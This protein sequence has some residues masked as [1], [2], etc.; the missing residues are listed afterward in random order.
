MRSPAFSYVDLAWPYVNVHVPHIAGGWKASCD[1]EVMSLESY[2]A[3]SD[4]I[5]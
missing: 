2:R 3:V 5:L 4:R 1:L